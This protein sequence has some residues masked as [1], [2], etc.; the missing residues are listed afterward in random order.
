[1]IDSYLHE[2]LLITPVVLAIMCTGFLLP[3]ARI[4]PVWGTIKVVRSRVEVV[5][6]G[7]G[8]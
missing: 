6:E 2:I 3:P 7:G 8:G 1:M 5:A 4:L